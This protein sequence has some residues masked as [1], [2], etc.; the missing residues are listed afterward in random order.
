MQG[1]APV[2]VLQTGTLAL[3]RAKR[4]SYFHRLYQRIGERHLHELSGLLGTGCAGR[5]SGAVLEQV[6]LQAGGAALFGLALGLG[7]RLRRQAEEGAC[8]C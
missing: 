7:I 8:I 4:G 5:S 3:K 6:S 1:Q 2:P